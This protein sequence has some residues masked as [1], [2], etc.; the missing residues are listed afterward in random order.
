MKR[1]SGLEKFLDTPPG[2]GWTSHT[3]EHSAL[4]GPF[5][6]RFR[7]PGHQD[8]SHYLL[9][10]VQAA[11]AS[12]SR[13]VN[14][15]VRVERTRV[16]AEEPFELP[17]FK[18]GDLLECLGRPSEENPE[19]LA[20]LAACLKASRA[21]NLQQLELRWS[22]GND[23]Y[24]L[25]FGLQGA[26]IHAQP[27][28]RGRFIAL[29]RTHQAPPSRGLIDMRLLT[30]L[31]EHRS[32]AARCAFSPVPVW[33]DGRQV[34]GPLWGLVKLFDQQAHETASFVVAER[35]ALPGEAPRSLKFPLD[36]ARY[37]A[38]VQ[39]IQGQRQ[40]DQAGWNVQT[41][42]RELFH[43]PGPAIWV[44]ILFSERPSQLVFVVNGVTADPIEWEGG[45]EGLLVV[46]EGDSLQLEGD[47][48]SVQ[49][50]DKFEALVK[51]IER[52]AH[53]LYDNLRPH[54]DG[55]KLGFK[56]MMAGAA[57]G[58]LAGSA[59]TPVGGLVLGAA[60]AAATLEGKRRHRLRS[61]A[62]AFGG[63]GS[64]D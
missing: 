34:T 37:P 10:F 47:E 46:A 35:F 28:H 27:A 62:R 25:A 49:Q 19:V 15:G 48:L 13:R 45:A 11:V 55:W 20:Q 60:T 26:T 56:G 53:L 23:T 64:G 52:E 42:F 43:R 58:A 3:F 7:Q 29:T 59:I 21:D 32:V 54:L 5:V 22:D 33:M 63:S 61:L 24:N 6:E 8:P 38:R 16:V 44:Q 57:V 50:D 17:P 18:A 30:R 4:L 2:L 39:F 14:V 9:K 12:R 41:Y 36:L 1:P 31:A 51:I 40:P